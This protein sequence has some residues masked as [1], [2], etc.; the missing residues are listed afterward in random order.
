MFSNSVVCIVSQRPRETSDRSPQF[1]FP[2]EG[3]DPF[4]P[5][6][7]DERRYGHKHHKHHHRPLGCREYNC[8]GLAFHPSQNGDGHLYLVASALHQF[9]FRS[10]IPSKTTIQILP[11]QKKPNFS[12]VLDTGQDTTPQIQLSEAEK[13]RLKLPQD[14]LDWEAA[15]DPLH[16]LTLAKRMPDPSDPSEDPSVDPSGAERARRTRR[17]PASTLG[18]SAPPRSALPRP[19][20]LANGFETHVSDYVTR[21]DHTDRIAECSTCFSI[22][23]LVH[24]CLRS[25]DFDFAGENKVGEIELL[26]EDF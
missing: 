17:A 11:L 15:R 2:G 5:G 25:E 14:Q 6:F 1:G 20:Q 4:A 22:G 10:R 13:P 19:R 3:F 21:R 23:A 7:D 24:E 9:H 26:F 12:S 16:R 18:P 8:G